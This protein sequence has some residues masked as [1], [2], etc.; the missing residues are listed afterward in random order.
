MLSRLIVPTHDL[1]QS[2]RIQRSLMAAG[3]SS[4]VVALLFISYLLDVLTLRAFVN[5][6]L[7]T[8]FFV[9]AFYAVF[10]GGLNLRFRDP[11]LTLPQI[12][13]STLVILY[14]LYESKH[15]HGVLALIYRVPC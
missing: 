15:A 1:K 5:S 9:I 7:L 3:A 4:M 13:C 2:H 6:A 14:A 8:A 12:L 11:S 10:R